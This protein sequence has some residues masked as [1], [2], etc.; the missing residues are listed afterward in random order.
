MFYLDLDPKLGL[1]R[2]RKRIS[3]DRIEAEDIAF[4]TKIREGYLAIQEK[5]PDHFRLLN[6]AQTP[7]AVFNQA[8]ELIK[9]LLR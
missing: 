6:A 5:N 9:L 1:A 7:E 8:I 2:T 3:L 4:H